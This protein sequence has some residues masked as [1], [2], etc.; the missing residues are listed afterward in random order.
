[1]QDLDTTDKKILLALQHN[2]RITNKELSNMLG[3]TITPVYE[4]V[5]KLERLGYIKKYTA[6]L[7][8]EKL[9]QGLI[10]FLHIKLQMHSNK[11]IVQ[12]MREVSE[13]EEVME[14][15][16]ITGETD[17][18]MKVMIKD[19]KL[20]ENFVVEKLAKIPGIANINSSI[21]MS[22][23]KHKTELNL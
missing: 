7:D 11:N 12:L 14:C 15:Y 22:T 13:L 3:L 17:Y 9:E 21:V 10:V 19:M 2:A 23:I 6:I 8:N 1:M 5:K 4:R 20:Y 16:H 18:L